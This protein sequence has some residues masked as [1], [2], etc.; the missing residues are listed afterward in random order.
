[1]R[2]L[3]NNAPGARILVPVALGTV[4]LEPVTDVLLHKLD[5]PNA[6][7]PAYFA[8]VLCLGTQVGENVPS[9]VFVAKDGDLG[10]EFVCGH[11]F[12]FK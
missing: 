8:L 1:M 4:R 6:Y 12:F 10:H 5:V 11:D 2:P 9:K 7:S 3:R